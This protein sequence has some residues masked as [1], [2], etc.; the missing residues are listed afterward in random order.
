MCLIK[1]SL[2][3]AMV[4]LVHESGL[5]HNPRN[6]VPDAPELNHDPRNFPPEQYY[7]SAPE[8]N[9]DPREFPPEVVS[10]PDHDGFQINDNEKKRISAGSWSKKRWA[11]LV[12]IL[13]IVAVVIGGSVGGTVGKRKKFANIVKR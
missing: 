5:E 3:N 11:Y 9:H 2:I 12:A 4:H 6:E 7:P 10:G 8:T 1:R 13:L